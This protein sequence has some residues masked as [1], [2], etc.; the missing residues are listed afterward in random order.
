MIKA[1]II[2]NCI[3][4]SLKLYNNIHY[5]IYNKKQK[6]TG[7]QK[8]LWFDTALLTGVVLC[9]CW[10]DCEF[11]SDRMQP[12]W[13]KRPNSVCVFEVRVQHGS[14]L[15]TAGILDKE[16]LLFTSGMWMSE[17]KM[18][19]ISIYSSIWKKPPQ[20]TETAFPFSC[21]LSIVI[22]HVHLPACGDV[23]TFWKPFERRDLGGQLTP[24][25]CI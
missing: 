15:A 7:Y 9:P 22:G 21:C 6:W 18:C 19:C 25:L 1:E 10:Y 23:S 16:Q 20:K 2:I 17:S 5:T 13:E 12:D 24:F 4:Q 11:C 8:V 3:K 14:N